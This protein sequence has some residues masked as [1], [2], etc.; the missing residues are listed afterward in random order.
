MITSVPSY[1]SNAMLRASY[2]QDTG[3]EI[4]RYVTNRLARRVSSE[5][6]GSR[7]TAGCMVS[8]GRLRKTNF[9]A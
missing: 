7:L 1:F 4:I 6:S 2:Y 3:F 5:R 9:P 8:V